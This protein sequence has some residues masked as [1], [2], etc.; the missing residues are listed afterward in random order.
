M[1]NNIAM[2]FQ[3]VQLGNP[4][5]AYAKVMGIQHAQNQNQLAQYQ[6]ESARR[7]D[8]DQNRLRETLAGFTPDMKP[9]EQYN[10]LVKTGNLDAARKLAESHAKVT[11]DNSDTAKNQREG[12]K[13][14]M[15]MLKHKMEIS[16]DF[17]SGIDPNA[18][19]TP[20][21]MMQW[22][23]GA[24][25]DPHIG[26]LMTKYGA[27]ETN[28]SDSIEQ[29]IKTPGGMDKLVNGWR[30]GATE[31]AKLNKPHFAQADDNGTI[32]QVQTPGM[33]GAPV[34]T[35]I[36][37]KVASP[38]AILRNQTDVSQGNRTDTV[39]STTTDNAGNVT[40]FNKFGQI[41]N[42]VAGA[43]K[44][45]G[46]FEKTAVLKKQQSQDINRAI[47]ELTD[48]AK[49][50]GLIDT[51]THSGV[52]ALMDSGA[53]FVG[54]SSKGADSAA[55][56]APIADLV[57]KMVPRFEGPQSDKDTASYKAAAGD[58]ANP[59]IPTSRKQAAAKTILRL[60]NDRKAQF[61]TKDIVESGG[62]IRPEAPAGKTV[63]RTGT[64]PDGRRVVQYSDGSH[65][66]AN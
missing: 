50:G 31:F 15:D 35:P 55:A 29:A 49:P 20:N 52:G 41:I 40:H 38:D 2:G 26:P 62:D 54:K 4:L 30:L 3:G 24:L 33:G 25:A 11:K 27:N 9:E 48:A 44:P 51:S 65:E 12:E 13:A 61:T 45:S 57:L 32:S 22:F 64:A 5:D 39:A 63:V 60:M 56:L 19:T 47:S 8:A 17:L 21:T 37:T 6:M 59:S 42:T 10:A 7:A 1:G 53:A 23:K 16:R 36:A 34:V 43:G 18:P 66:Y 14:G 28:L 46:T 58:L